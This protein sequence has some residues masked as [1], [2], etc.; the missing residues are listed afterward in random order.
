MDADSLIVEV[1]DTAVVSLRRHAGT[2]HPVR[3]A[4]RRAEGWPTGREPAAET[5]EERG[6]QGAQRCSTP[7]ATRIIQGARY[8]NG[9]PVVKYETA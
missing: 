2:E 6:V 3:C 9:V 8:K 7:Q 5:A 1:G 4:A